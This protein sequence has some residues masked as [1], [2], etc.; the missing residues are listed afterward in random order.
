MYATESSEMYLENILVLS[1]RQEVVRA[2]DITHYSGYSKPSV[3]RAMGILKQN[4]HIVVD[5]RGHIT[6]TSTGRAIAEKIL[7]RHRILTA[8]LIKLGVDP[9]TASADACKIEHDISDTTFDALK[10]YAEG[11]SQK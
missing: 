6:L 11:L 2:I 7:E 8:L 9:E 3:S 4:G 10:R 5:G 1:E